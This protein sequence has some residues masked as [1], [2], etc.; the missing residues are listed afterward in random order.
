[1]LPEPV[2]IRADG[3]DEADCLDTECCRQLEA[4][5]PAAGREERIPSPESPAI[6][7]SRSSPGIGP[8]GVGKSRTSPYLRFIHP[9]RS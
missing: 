2:H 5:V 9:F 8:R 3:D 1:M 7:W 6:T 4:E